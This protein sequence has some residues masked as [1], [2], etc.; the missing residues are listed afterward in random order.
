[1]TDLILHQF[2]HS[3]FCD[4]VRRILHWK[5]LAYQV[6]EIALADRREIKKL[7]GTGKLPCLEHQGQFISD[8]TN[9]AHYLDKTFPDRPV[10]PD[11]PKE[12]AQVHLMEDWADE[13]LY[14]YLLRLCYTLPHNAKRHL[15]RL[16]HVDTGSYR[17]I[18]PGIVP[19]GISRILYTQGSGRKSIEQAM[20]EIERHIS[21]IAELVTDQ[22]WLVGD[23]L[24]LADISVFSQLNGLI[25]TEE[26]EQII[27]DYPSVSRWMKRVN[28]VTSR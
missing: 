28:Q 17:K 18:A 15:P 11:S 14:F 8:S 12:L 10:L 19:A 5:E 27:G 23:E 13:S 22:D 4:K 21:A 1:M 20:A 3:P 6:N 25:E 24:T 2:E 16:L 9:I 26:G 7:N